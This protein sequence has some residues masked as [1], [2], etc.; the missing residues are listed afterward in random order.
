MPSKRRFGAA[1]PKPSKA[2]SS[3]ERAKPLCPFCG[4]P[5]GSSPTGR[6]RRWC[7][8][9]CRAEGHREVARLRNELRELDR[10]LTLARAQANA[11]MVQYR[12]ARIGAVEGR[13]AVL[14][15]APM[16]PRI[17]TG[18][19]TGPP[20]AGTGRVGGPRTGPIAEGRSQHARPPFE[21]KRHG[22]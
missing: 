5:I 20:G 2:H 7:S 13:L 12:L 21:R 16:T 14:S 4:D 22:E 19:P 11:P 8:D 9:R 1:V 10:L 17:A 6:P 3:N 18:S 15:G